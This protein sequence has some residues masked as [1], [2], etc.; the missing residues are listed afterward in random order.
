MLRDASLVAFVPVTDLTRAQEFYVGIVGLELQH[1][2]DYGC[3]LRSNGT[4]VRL[5]LVEE[6]APPP[7]TALGWEVASIDAAVRALAGAGVVFTRYDGMEQ[8]ALGIWQA[9]SGDR[10]AW[11]G[12][13]EGNTLSLTQAG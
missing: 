1:A 2:D 4:T 5:A 8:D 11:F 13:S 12:D 9:P 10:V 6:Y 7:F 3:M